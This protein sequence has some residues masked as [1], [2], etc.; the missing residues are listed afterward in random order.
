[1]IKPTTAGCR[2]PYP[3]RDRSMPIIRTIEEERP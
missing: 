3:L 1:M 2:W